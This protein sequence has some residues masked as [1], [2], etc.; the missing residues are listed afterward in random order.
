MAVV[1]KV[2]QSQDTIELDEGFSVNVLT[3]HC[4]I[5]TRKRIRRVVNVETD[6]LQKQSI[7]EIPY[8]DEGLCCA[9]AIV[10]ALAHLENKMRDIETLRKLNRLALMSECLNV[11]ES[12]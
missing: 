6:C 7:L 11:H 2:L 9:K 12:N 1:L 5:S 8:D 3:L 10:F 4:D